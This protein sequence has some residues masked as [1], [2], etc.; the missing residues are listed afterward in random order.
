M[1]GDELSREI[2]IGRERFWC[3]PYLSMVSSGLPFL[4]YRNA[5]VK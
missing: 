3:R 5:F 1:V 4:R 2:S